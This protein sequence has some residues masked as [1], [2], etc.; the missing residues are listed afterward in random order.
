[1]VFL[2]NYGFENPSLKIDRFGRKHPTYANYATVK[3][4][5]GKVAYCSQ[6]S[7]NNFHLSLARSE[8][9]ISNKFV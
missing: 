7:T 6:G 9:A 8:D 1:M 4:F 5:L 3:L 2:K